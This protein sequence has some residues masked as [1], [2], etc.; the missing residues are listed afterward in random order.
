MGR[1]NRPSRDED[2]G[3]VHERCV[4]A[5]RRGERRASGER[6]TVFSDEELAKIRDTLGWLKTAE[7]SFEFW[8]DAAD[9]VVR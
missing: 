7:K 3:H 9:A 4:R 1:Y 6:Y 8:N 2:Q 5:A